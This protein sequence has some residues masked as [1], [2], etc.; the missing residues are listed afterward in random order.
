MLNKNRRLIIVGASSFG[1]EIESWLERVPE[2]SR[3]WIIGG[4][5]DDNPDAR[6]VIDFPSSYEFLGTIDNTEFREDD[7]CIVA[8]A[9]PTY[10]RN[11]VAKLRG[12]I[13]FF[14]F[15]SPDSIIGK[16]NIIGEGVIVCPGTIITTNV[17]LGDF[18]TVNNSC[19]IGH[20]VVVGDYSS[21]MGSVTL[22]GGVNL[23]NDV[24]VG[25]KSTITPKISIA[26]GSKVGA[27]S[28]VIKNVKKPAVLFGNPAKMIKSV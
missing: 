17:E 1:R 24:Y 15:I 22:S 21:L 28:V 6:G 10:K 13:E 12:R 25:S 3:D 9:E 16:F 7:F 23:G 11:V 5:V 20:D 26:S 14:S 19:N 4:Y 2:K 8:I 18:V 27:G